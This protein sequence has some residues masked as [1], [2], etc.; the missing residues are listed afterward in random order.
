MHDWHLVLLSFQRS[1]SSLGS[2]SKKT[3]PRDALPT[4]IFSQTLPRCVVLLLLHLLSAV[5]SCVLLIRL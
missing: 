5:L 4:S 3:Q 2:G 1:S